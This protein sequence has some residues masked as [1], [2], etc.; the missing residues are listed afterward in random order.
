ME[1]AYSRYE[2]IE[3]LGTGVTSR[4]DKARDTVIGRTVAL[5]TFLQGFGSCDLRQQF[6]REAQII[7]RLSHPNIVA[8]YDVGTNKD[9]VPY[10]VME[11]VPGRTLEAVMAGGGALPLARTALWAGDLAGALSLAHRAN[12]IHGDVKPANIIVTPEGQVKLGDFGVARF[13]TQTSSYGKVMGTPAYLSPEQILGK[14]QETRSDLF[15]LGIILYQMSCGARPFNGSSIGAVCAQ[16]ISCDPPPPSHYNPSLPPAFDRVVMR[17]LAKDPAKRYP[18]AEALASSLYPFA[19]NNAPV[20]AKPTQLSLQRKL[21]SWWNR[22][23]QKRDIWAAAAGLVLILTTGLVINAAH[24]RSVL[25]ASAVP[26][27]NLAALPVTSFTN[28]SADASPFVPVKTHEISLVD[29]GG[30]HDSPVVT[31]D[32][33]PSASAAPVKVSRVRSHPASPKKSEK[34]TALEPIPAPSA[35][36]STTE[37]QIAR[38]QASPRKDTGSLSIQVLSSVAN[39]TLAIYAGSELLLSTPLESAHVGETLH[40]DRPLAVGSHPLRV[41]LYNSNSELHVQ[42][43]GLA[44]VVADG[45]NTLGIRVNRRPKLL[46]RKETALEISWPNQLSASA[47]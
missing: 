30:T 32:P 25:A 26:A 33:P 23:L 8:L 27:N 46:I 17:C 9:G 15:S 5:K 35:L 21:L 37:K 36:P 29:F 22:P 24:K 18:T 14:L 41:A 20:Q 10:F 3:T 16:I 34:K 39:E 44:E 4:V 47:R 6:A 7:G 12:I 42:K 19:R 11:Y 31:K 40:F 28:P 43:E 1:T 2:I 45:Q 38:E 13:A